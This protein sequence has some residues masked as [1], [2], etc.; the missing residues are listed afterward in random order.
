MAGG[1]GEGLGGSGGGIGGGGAGGEG[2][3]GTAGGGVG[4]SGAKP[5]S[6][7]VTPTATSKLCGAGNSANGCI[8]DMDGTSAG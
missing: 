3:G 5:G 6:I 4:G 8:A 7:F 1:G 2:G